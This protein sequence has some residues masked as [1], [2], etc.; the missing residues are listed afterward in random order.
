MTMEERTQV[1]MVGEGPDAPDCE[2]SRT[3]AFGR[4]SNGRGPVRPSVALATC[5]AIPDL[6]PEGRQLAAALD[7]RGAHAFPAVWDSGDVD[8]DGCDL[9]VIRTTE[10]WFRKPGRFLAWANRIGPRLHNPP[11]MVAWNHD[12][13]RYLQDLAA[14]G[15]PVIPTAYAPP[16]SDPQ[17]PDGKIVIKPSVA[18]GSHGAAAHLDADGAREHVRALHQGGRTAMIQPWCERVETDGE[19]AV[20]FVDG[21]V[22][23]AVCK[24]AILRPGEPPADSRPEAVSRCRLPRDMAAVARRAMALA[25]GRFGTPLYGRADMLRDDR[26]RPALLELE[27]IEPLLFLDLAPGSAGRLADALLRRA[28][29]A[30]AGVSR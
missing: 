20:V 23:H 19:T 28:A 6:L 9:V 8:W 25:A 4:A 17:I 26:G 2:R 5:T 30:P 1:G 14:V 27:L 10:D 24:A 7:E 16:G 13:R 18:A 21:R 12:K 3:A 11:P 29:L 22:S 15:V